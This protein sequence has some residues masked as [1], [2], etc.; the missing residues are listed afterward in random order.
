MSRRGFSQFHQLMKLI[1]GS[2]PSE[3][4]DDPFGCGCAAV[5]NMRARIASY[6]ESEKLSTMTFAEWQQLTPEAAAREIHERVR[7]RLSP[8][9][10]RAVIARL[11]PEDRLAAALHA[12]AAFALRASASSASA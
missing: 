1:S 12:A 2:S 11:E 8:V 9:Q 5:G 6:P 10:Q 7:Q 4:E 3:T